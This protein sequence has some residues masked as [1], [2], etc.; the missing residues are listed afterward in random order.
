[1]RRDGIPIERAPIV[2]TD[3]PRTPRAADPLPESADTDEN[4]DEEWH[5]LI[6]D[7]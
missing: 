7:A 3:V 4:A 1:M 2:I 6:E 5:I